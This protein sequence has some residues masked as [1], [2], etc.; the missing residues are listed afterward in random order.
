MS[1]PTPICPVCQKP[2]VPDAPQGLCPG[3]LIKTGFESRSGKEPAKS[4]VPPT[5]DEMT[6]LFPQL[7]ILGLLGQGGMGA[8][9]KARQLRLNRFVALKILARERQDDPQFAERFEREARAL[10]ALTHPHIVAVFDFGEAG[11][12]YYLLMEFVDGL[13]LRQ[14]YRNGQFSPAEALAIIPQICDALQYAHERGIVHRDIKPENI[15]LDNDGGVKIADF[16]LA[17][18]LDPDPKDL[19]LTGINQVVGTPHY[20]APEQL[21]KPLT[22]DCRADIYSVG[23][24]FYEMLTG[25]LP[26]GKFPPPSQKAHLDARLDQVVLQALE[27]EPTLRYQKVE[28]VKSALENITSAPAQKAKTATIA[29]PAL[30]PPV[31]MASRSLKTAIVISGLAAVTIIGVLAVFLFYRFRK[32]EPHL[33]ADAS[34]IHSNS[35]WNLLN[36]NQRAVVQHTDRKYRTLFDGLG[37]KSSVSTQQRAEL[38]ESCLKAVESPPSGNSDRT[39]YYRSINTLGAM[40][41]DKALPV[42]MKI[43]S[44]HTSK[45]VWT[46]KSNRDRWMAARALGMIGHKEAVPQLISLLYHP[47]INTRWSAQIALVQLTGQNFGGDWNAWAK[48]WNSQKLQPSIGPDLVR[49]WHGQENPT[50]LIS[51][52]AE[53][54]RNFFDSVGGKRG[55]ISNTNTTNQLKTMS[56]ILDLDPGDG[57]K[58][59]HNP[60]EVDIRKAVESLRDDSEPSFLILK[61]DAGTMLQATC[62]AKDSFVIQIQEGEE[63]HQYQSVKNLSTDAEFTLGF[64][65]I[66]GDPDWKKLTNWKSM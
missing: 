12:N 8:V 19:S 46:E 44:A 62:V 29:P 48:W 53:H 1:D 28:E 33:A 30:K 64:A 32:Q 11:E 47:S 45:L 25:E 36:D 49:W 35:F 39:Q 51:S 15:L 14:L 4:F 43:V 61:K 24:V 56:N 41:S 66:K 20:M 40:H 5:V 37:V 27:K 38:E 34:L 3:C 23:V 7:E 18:I 63:K 50:N 26:L 6:K 17:K 42:L 2:S 59:V 54:D 60:T 13:N 22:V 58:A 16:G 65:F 21:E 55:A 52:I 31:P 9:Y 10:A 57:S